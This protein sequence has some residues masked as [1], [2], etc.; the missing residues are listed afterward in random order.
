[1]LFIS[2]T[3]PHVSVVLLLELAPGGCPVQRLTAG[4]SAVCRALLKGAS[5]EVLQRKNQDLKGW[6]TDSRVFFLIAVQITDLILK[7]HLS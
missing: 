6:S 5:G 1:M 2:N 7:A 3:P 4:N